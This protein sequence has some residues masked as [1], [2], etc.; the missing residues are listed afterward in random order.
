MADEQ[1]QEQPFKIYL[2]G[3]DTVRVHAADYVFQSREG[4]LVL[5]NAAGVEVALFRTRHVV[6]IVRDDSP[7]VV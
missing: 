5:H 6:G 1:P 3:G 4:M 2:E 7:V